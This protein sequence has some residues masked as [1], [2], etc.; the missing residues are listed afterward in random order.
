M[1]TM[2]RG[3]I[4]AKLWIIDSHIKAADKK[5]I[6][7]HQGGAFLLNTLLSMGLSERDIRLESMV[8][9]IPRGNKFEYFEKNKPEVITEGVARL[10]RSIK[11]CKPNLVLLL[12]RFPMK[13]LL[14]QSSVADWRGHVVWSERLGCKLLGTLA[15]ANAHRQKFVHKSLKP[16]QYLALMINDLHKTKYEMSFAGLK[17]VQLNPII[18]PTFNEARTVLNEMY[19]T[20]E[21]LSYDIETLK[22]YDAHFM[23]CIGFASS[24]E[25]G[26]CIPLYYPVNTGAKLFYSESETVALLE[27]ICK[28]LGSQIPK[29]AQNSKFD[30]AILQQWYKMP[31]VNLVWDTMVLAHNLYC[32]LPK[33]LGTLISLYTNLPYH[34]YLIHEG[35]L[36]SRWEYN[37]VDAIANLHVLE[38]E[39][40]EARELGILDH[41]QR[42][43]HPSIRTTVEMHLQGVPVD[44]ELR[45][46]AMAKEQ[47]IMRNILWAFDQI[48]PYYIDQGKKAKH[49]FNPNSPKQKIGL[50][51]E[52]LGCKQQHY[53]GNISMNKYVMEGLAKNGHNDL[54]RVCAEACMQYKASSTMA[55]KLKTPTYKG[56]LCTQYDVAGTDTGRLNSKQSETLPGGTN[57]QNLSKGLQRQMLIPPK[58]GLWDDV[59]HLL[60]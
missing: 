7:T 3:N 50:F 28:L 49:K 20:A 40:E 19:E 26:I 24:L 29:V 45:D 35:G 51:V 57:L 25:F 30:T 33:D 56:K 5:E 14:G 12:G 16:G 8:Y 9:E 41:Y 22:P 53:E 39:I 47:A 54:V 17:Q 42:V 31:V 23:D 59:K 44:E 13:Y 18:K 55:G 21:I 60:R 37:A 46:S 34:K 32:D 27:L 11:E 6:F 2:G 4:N 43:T 48:L 36:D 58:G 10:E 1:I 38:G 15:P 52:G